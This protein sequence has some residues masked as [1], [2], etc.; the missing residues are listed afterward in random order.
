MLYDTIKHR[1]VVICIVTYSSIGHNNT[2]INSLLFDTST[3]NKYA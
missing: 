1:N 2:Y 3:F